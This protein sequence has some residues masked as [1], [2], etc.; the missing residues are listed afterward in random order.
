MLLHQG[1]ILHYRAAIYNRLSAYLR[2]R[3]WHLRVVAESVQSD[4]P[5]PVSFDHTCCRPTVRDVVAA[6]GNAKPDALI[7]FVNLKERYLFPALI[8]AKIAGLPVIYWGHAIDLED[9]NAVVK[10]WLYR[11]E[12][13]L[14]DALIL[15]ADWLRRYVDLRH[16]EKT[17]IANNTIDT[18]LLPRHPLSKQDWRKRLGVATTRNIVSVGRMQRRKRIDQLVAAFSRIADPDVGLILVGPDVDGVAKEIADPRIK[19]VGPRYGEEL[20]GYMQLA[21]V[22]CMP[23]H[24]GLSIVDA[25]YYGLPFITT[26]VEHAP[27][28]M[29]LKDGETG[30]IVPANS[31]DALSDALRSLLEND[32]LRERMGRRAIEVIQNEGSLEVMFRGFSD[33]LAHVSKH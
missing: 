26:D 14:C 23:G 33:A 29:Y 20:A 15:Y 1:V 4:S 6:I 10:R 21:D 28:I 31:V 7:L 5:H 22:Y 9:K 11:L 32:A 25:M 18:S 13:S 12:H 16:Y 3:G 17:F 24:V 8:R 2:Q 30:L 27:E 19:W